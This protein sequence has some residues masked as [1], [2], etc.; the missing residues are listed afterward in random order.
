MLTTSVISVSG[1]FRPQ[2]RTVDTIRYTGGLA[3]MTF[4]GNVSQGFVP[5][6]TPTAQQT[7]VY[8]SY[9]VKS[10]NVVLLAT[11]AKTD[12]S[13]GKAY[14]VALDINNTTY[15]LNWSAVNSYDDAM[16]YY[17]TAD[18]PWIKYKIINPI[19]LL[20]DGATESHQPVV[21]TANWPVGSLQICP[22]QSS[23]DVFTYFFVWEV[24]FT[25]R[26]NL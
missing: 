7:Q 18:S 25:R 2:K 12:A 24:D 20:S 6:Y 16:I 10:C 9:A 1:G 23:T 14:G 11:L 5:T 13:L 15:G 21:M 26:H 19:R 22:T 8:D 4:A 17:P 3:T